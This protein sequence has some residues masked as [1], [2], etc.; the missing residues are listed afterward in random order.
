MDARS[1]GARSP[2]GQDGHLGLVHLRAA[3]VSVVLDLRGGSLP[4][5]LHWGADLGQLDAAALQALALLAVPP[6]T[7]NT[8]DE[9]GELAL[10]PEH[11]AGWFGTPGL[12]GQRDGTDWSPRFTTRTAQVEALD[13]GHR[14][15]AEADDVVA[16][17]R[18]GLELELTATGLVRTRA[19]LVNDGDLPYRLEGLLLALPVPAE[20]EELLDLTGGHTRERFPQRQPFTVGARVRDNRRGRTGTDAT[21]LMVAGRTA[22]GARD[23]EVWGLHVGWSGNHRTYAERLSSGDAVLGGGELLLPGEVVLAPAGTYGSPWLYASYGQGLDELSQRFHEWLRRRPEHPTRRRPRPVTLNTWEAVYMDHDRARLFALADAAAEVGAERYVLD[24][25][26]FRGRRDDTSGLGDWYVDEQVYPHGLHPLVQHV[27]GLGLEFGLWVEPEMVSPDSD[28]ARA[29]P[30]WVMGTGGRAPFASRHQQ[31]LDLGLAEA[32]AYVLERLDALLTEYAVDYLKWDHNRDLH[33][34]GRRP[35]GEPGVHRQTLAVYRLMDELK[36]R[37]PGL[38]IESCSSGGGRVDLGVMARA[39]RVWASDSNDPL[40]RQRIQRWTGLLLPPELVGSHVGPPRSHTT[41]RTHDLA[42]RAGTAFFG[43]LGIEWDLTAATPAERAELAQWVALHKRFRRLLHAGRVVRG[44]HPDGDV[45][46]HGVVAEEGD[47]AVL[48]V[49]STGH[50]AW[51][52]PGRVR[53][54]GLLPD[55]R[56]RLELLTPPSSV[57]TNDTAP[58]PWP[59]AGAVAAPGSVLGRVGVEI[60]GLFPEQLLL[61]HLAAVDAGADPS[62][63]PPAR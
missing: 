47:E 41:G 39:D 5:V 61:L 11:S 46:V 12:S 43:H 59:T 9:P 31:V 24:D 37:H 1:A 32:Y 16:R 36:R 45:S 17:L 14:L 63:P 44:D 26:W 49:V 4:R 27:R 57:R 48:A 34:A 21:L 23:G 52:R 3:G 62:P 15:V 25:G 38:E 53:L 13:G 30:D 6:V 8:L 40:E 20:A 33:D 19:T 56:Y 54:P 2:A 55:T 22:F 60:P 29:H 35:D 51:T 18:L 7:S 42:F 28:L 50:R 10:L 58:A